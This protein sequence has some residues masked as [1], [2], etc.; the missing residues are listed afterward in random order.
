MYFWDKKD[1]LKK[2][3]IN[4]KYHNAYAENDTLTPA[5]NQNNLVTSKNSKNFRKFLPVNKKL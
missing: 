1:T 2:I 3:Q 5:S 4:I